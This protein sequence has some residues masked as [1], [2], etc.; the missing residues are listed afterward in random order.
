MLSEGQKR[1][2]QQ[3][4]ML[5]LSYRDKSSTL[6]VGLRK[7]WNQSSRIGGIPRLIVAL[8]RAQ[9]VDFSLVAIFSLFEGATR[10]A[11]P[12]FLGQLLRGLERGNVSQMYK[13][14]AILSILSFAQTIIHHVLFFFSMRMGF[15]WRTATSSLIFNHMLSLKTFTSS[16]RGT[17]NL[18]SLISTDVAIFDHFAIVSI[19]CIHIY[20]ITSY[21]LFFF[22]FIIVTN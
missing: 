14:A 20:F 16:Q 4:D 5:E 19:R 12:Y 6:L 2:L 8:A 15:N 7:E 3:K 9:Y 17:G 13:Y 11:L 22:P 10:V 21:T 1:P 18:V